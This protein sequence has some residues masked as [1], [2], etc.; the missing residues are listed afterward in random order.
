M[1]SKPFTE[2]D[3]TD[4]NN[5][6]VPV[7]PYQNSKTI[8]ERAAWEWIEKEGGSM[9]LS[10]INPVGIFGPALG[11]DSSTSIILVKRLMMGEMPGVP[12]LQLGSVDVRDTADVHLLAMTSPKAAGQRFL[13]VSDDG[14]LTLQEIARQLKARMGDK[15]KKVPTRTL[16]NILLRLVALFDAEVG[17]IVPELGKGKNALNTKAKETLGWKPMSAMDSIQASAESLI[18]FGVVK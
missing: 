5:P 7:A 1:R 17:L 6:S 11:K 9:E 16:P 10:V 12:Q 3:W 15:G 14:F 8:A 4:L 18:E 13:A 2:E